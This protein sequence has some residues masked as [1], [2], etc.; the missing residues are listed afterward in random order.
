MVRNILELLEILSILYAFAAI[1]GKKLVYNIYSVL[2]IITEVILMIGINDYG[3]PAYFVS[4]SYALMFL[5][6]LLNYKKSLI[7]TLIN[8]VLAGILVGI[9]QLLVYFVLVSVFRDD[10]INDL[11]LELCVMIG[12]FGIT[13]FVFP[14]LHLQRISDFLMRRKWISL[15]IGIAV[16]GIFGSQLWKI[17]QNA[18]LSGEDFIITVYFYALLFLLLIEWQKTRIDA[19]KRK[20]QLEMNNLYYEA[21]EELIGSIRERQHE[22]KNHLNAIKGILYT[23]TT[24][25]ELKAQ[26]ERYMDEIIKGNEKTSI[27]TMVENPLL[28]GFLSVKIHEAESK[29]IYVKYKCVFPTGKL[30]IPEYQLVE[31]LGILLDNAIEE[32]EQRGDDRKYIAINLSKEEK[33]MNFSVINTCRIDVEKSNISHFFDK[34][35]SSKGDGRGIGLYKLR[36]MVHKEQGEIYAAQDML[37]DTNAIKLQ[38]LLPV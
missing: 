26:E 18:K 19:E 32:T 6:C 1:Y 3:M 15:G 25:E 17:K 24:Y 14:K 21:Y 2:F 33:D 27:L 31:M 34:G 12:C 30:A 7:N 16:A 13:V 5:F 22:F 8:T 36:E 9:L 38:I 28:A 11:A 29:G 20:I 10:N 23:A 4:L 37:N 35:Y